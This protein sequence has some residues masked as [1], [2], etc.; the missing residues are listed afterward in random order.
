MAR[1]EAAARLKSF[2]ERLEKLEE[3]EVEVLGRL[4]I[5]GA[6]LAE[7]L[8][9]SP[10][11]TYIMQAGDAGHVKI[12]RARDV[13]A[14]R[15]SLQTGSSVPLKVIRIIHFDCERDLHQ[16]YAGH[17]LHGEWFS[18]DHSMLSD[19]FAEKLLAEAQIQIG[20]SPCGT[21]Q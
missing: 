18:F 5:A 2:I 1:T 14:R 20:Q 9:K 17:R 11:K 8:G 13:E 10:V 15:R 21:I 4:R 19:G 7:F 6:E 16:R 3:R 12:G